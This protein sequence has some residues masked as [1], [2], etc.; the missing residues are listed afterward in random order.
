MACLSAIEYIWDHEG[1]PE[2]Y[3]TKAHEKLS[4]GLQ[5]ECGWHGTN[6]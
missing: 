5:K 1:G 4:I 2:H 6:M 3:E